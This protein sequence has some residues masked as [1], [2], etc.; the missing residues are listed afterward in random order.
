MAPV[1]VPRAS[2][3]CRLRHD[4]GHVILH[5]YDF[6][7]TAIQYLPKLNQ[8]H[9]PQ[10]SLPQIGHHTDQLSSLGYITLMKPLP[11]W[12]IL[13]AVIPG[14]MLAGL[15]FI[16]HSATSSLLQDATSSVP[17]YK[18]S[19][20]WDLCII[21]L[22]VLLC[23]IFGL[24]FPCGTLYQSQLHVRALT[25]KSNDHLVIEERR[26]LAE[27]C[28]Q[29]MSGLAASIFSAAFILPPA[30]WIISKVPLAVLTGLLS[31]QAVHFDGNWDITIVITD[32]FQ[33]KQLR[34][35]P[36][37]VSYSAVCVYTVSQLSCVLIILAVSKTPAAV[38][39]PLFI[40]MTFWVRHSAMHRLFKREEF[41]ELDM[42]L[43]KECSD[44]SSSGPIS[45]ASRDTHA[46]GH[47]QAWPK[48]SITHTLQSVITVPRADVHESRQHES[49]N[50]D[51]IHAD[52]IAESGESPLP[53]PISPSLLHAST[54]RLKERSRRRGK[55]KRQTCADNMQEVSSEQ[56]AEEHPDYIPPLVKAMM[57]GH[58]CPSAYEEDD[59]IYLN[60]RVSPRLS[61][62]FFRK[63]KQRTEQDSPLEVHSNLLYEPKKQGTKQKPAQSEEPS[64]T[65]AN[66]STQE[67]NDMEIQD[68][69]QRLEF[70]RFHGSPGIGR[71]IRSPPVLK[72]QSPTRRRQLRFSIAIPRK[73]AFPK[74]EIYPNNV[75]AQPDAPR[76]SYPRLRRSS[77][78]RW[79]TTRQASAHMNHQQQLQRH[80]TSTTNDQIGC[81]I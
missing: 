13:L 24:P 6:L 17:Q 65:V 27:I 41:M 10:V 70:G 75:G 74:E 23:G 50:V 36:Q 3:I 63:S 40:F 35:H 12:A 20:K 45:T 51:G 28:F 4:F 11:I 15:I 72:F 73:R 81:V 18:N 77:T 37:C 30:R 22:L 76:K 61:P 55:K 7:V 59:D 25:L 14:I 62:Q 79:P 80:S 68:P 1:R 54:R 44:M 53:L 46:R 71:C 9:V 16:Y 48:I 5:R 31:L 19:I 43:I 49:I 69:N 38:L 8:T 78:S 42:T 2:C 34:S 56:Q 60:K 57:E 47:Q 52:F 39:F 58:N 26:G 33:R 66:V 67:E 64:P 29:R 32:I 21:T